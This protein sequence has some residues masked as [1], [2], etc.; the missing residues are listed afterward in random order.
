MTSPSL[1]LL[2]QCR[3]LWRCVRDGYRH[4][5]FVAAA[6]P[7][8]LPKTLVP[9]TSRMQF[10][11]AL[12]SPIN[13]VI[14]QQHPAFCGFA[15]A[16]TVALAINCQRMEIQEAHCENRVLGVMCAAGAGATAGASK[17][18]AAATENYS[19]TGTNRSEDRSVSFNPERE[20]L[21]LT[22]IYLEKNRS[23]LEF[24]HE[25]QTQN[26][27]KELREA[28]SYVVVSP[29]GGG[30][31]GAAVAGGKSSINEDLRHDPPPAQQQI[32]SFPVCA[33]SGFS[34][35]PQFRFY[36][37]FRPEFPTEFFVHCGFAVLDRFPA[38]VK[39]KLLQNL[40]MY[41]GAPL[42]ALREY[43]DSTPLEKT[44]KRLL[45]PVTRTEYISGEELTLDRFRT[46]IL[47]KLT[48]RGSTTG[49]PPRD[50]AA[51]AGGAA[52]GGPGIGSSSPDETSSPAPAGDQLHEGAD[53]TSNS[54]SERAMVHRSEDDDPFFVIVS[55]SRTEVG[56]KHF[57]GGHV[58]PI[59]GFD[60][61]TDRVLLLDVNTWRY[62]AVWIPAEALCNGIKT[63]TSVGIW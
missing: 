23:G 41:D 39:L 36:D 31:A 29:R 25:E 52:G 49:A 18:S 40:L 3:N 33:R 32:S 55:Y 51:G 11:D 17:G 16:Q 57:S 21:D 12:Y 43:F 53:S 35:T 5:K 27:A 56:Q 9:Y 14:V 62:P 60:P 19:E 6:N 38:R 30:G 45:P 59:A 8:E 44:S 61:A 13:T 1:S 48:T 46:E 2:A 22:Y 15:A 7:L 50:D 20:A 24:L 4:R 34:L 37:V 10:P 42:V 58:A 28:T 47:E 26:S 63:L 54:V